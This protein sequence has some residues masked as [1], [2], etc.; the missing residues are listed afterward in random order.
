[1]IPILPHF[2]V[3]PTWRFDEHGNLHS[4]NSWIAWLLRLGN[5]SVRF[6]MNEASRTFH[7]RRVNFW[8]HV[9]DDTFRC[10]EVAEV[11]V[12]YQDLIGWWGLGLV[13]DGFEIVLRLRDG[14]TLRM[15]NFSGNIHHPHLPG[16]LSKIH[17]AKLSQAQHE[18]FVFRSMVE[19]LRARFTWDDIER[20][21]RSLAT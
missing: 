9:E 12:E 1:M 3:G 14:R 17:P 11:T 19:C 5:A 7:L 16:I 8:F 21:D 13:C 15:H 2:Y 4:R 6:E 10:E 18:A 20:T